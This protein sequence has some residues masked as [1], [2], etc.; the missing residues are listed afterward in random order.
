MLVD[1][2]DLDPVKPGRV[3]DQDPLAFGQHRVIGGIPRDAQAF[4]DAGDGQVLADQPV[5][6]P[7]QAGATDLLAWCHRLGEVLAPHVAAVG[8]EVAAVP[9]DQD[10][11]PPPER[12]VGEAAGDRIAWGA[13][14]SAA[15]APRIR[16]GHAAEDFGFRRGEVLADRG[17]AQAVEAG[18]G[19]EIR[20]GKGRLVHCRGL[21]K[22]VV[23]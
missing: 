8:A 12:C 10:G 19:R 6:G 4:G 13:F 20:C 15:G 16:C 5:Q 7:G 11:G 3:A 21:S 18:E 9:D 17:E 22:K 2:E 14:G 23:W 1:T